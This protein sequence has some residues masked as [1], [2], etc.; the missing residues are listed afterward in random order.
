MSDTRAALGKQAEDIAARFIGHQGLVVIARNFK[1]KAAE[2]DIIARDRD[3]VCFIE[4]KARSSDRFGLPQEAVGAL[5]QHK[6]VLAAQ[7]FLKARKLED[8]RCRFDVV[9][10]MMGPGGP[11]CDF[12]RSAF[13]AV[14]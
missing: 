4:V 6:I 1:T 8:A 5:K 9:S 7:E 2:I 14:E 11:V 12:I 3:V 13:D 10:V